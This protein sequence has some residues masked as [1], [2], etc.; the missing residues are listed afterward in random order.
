MSDSVVHHNDSAP[1]T[2]RSMQS[3]HPMQSD[4]AWMSHW[5]KKSYDAAGLSRI[6]SSND[7]Y[8]TKE[9]Q[10]STNMETLSNTHGIFKGIEKIAENRTSEI[11][12]ESLRMTSTAIRNENMEFRGFLTDTANRKGEISSGLKFTQETCNHEVM[13]PLVNHNLDFEEP[14]LSI[15]RISVPSL[16]PMDSEE[17]N[18]TSSG[19][20]H[21]KHDESQNENEP[22]KTLALFGD[23]GFSMSRTWPVNFTAS[24]SHVVQHGL[25]HGD[26]RENSHPINVDRSAST[27]KEQ[28][29]HTNLRFLEREY[30]RRSE[31]L[32]CQ[33]KIESQSKTELPEDSCLRQDKGLFL[34]IS[35][36]TKNN[37]SRAFGGE[38]LQNIQKFAGFRPSQSEAKFSELTKSEKL[39][40]GYN[41]IPKFLN[42]V[43]DTGTMRICTAVDSVVGVRA[44]HPKF[45]QTTRNFFI[46]KKTD[47]NLNKENETFRNSIVSVDGN[48]FSNIHN[49]SPPSGH[50]KI[51]KLQPIHG[52]EEADFEENAKNAN[53]SSRFR[54][55]EETSLHDVEDLFNYK[56]D[57]GKK[58]EHDMVLDI[59]L[60][61]E[62][63][64]ETDIME[65]DEFEEKNQF[66][67]MYNPLFDILIHG[68]VYSYN[69]CCIFHLIS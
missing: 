19:D 45:S 8:G 17:N 39:H 20:C 55:S 14:T 22:V 44:G 32:V 9:Y 49:R 6:R 65:L 7:D 47:I 30:Q 43:H 15:R 64:A 16:L 60:K 28:L 61:N 24:T 59:N 4:S 50:A 26:V 42:S 38:Q 35:P 46:T 25:D 5:T 2:E 40:H 11:A 10:S 18:N 57:K 62:S 34:Q 21:L 13:R 33:E 1:K 37:H 56:E 31:I 66:S 63:S 48:L 12:N 23:S 52:F 69:S 58:V 3:Y 53:A 36:S 54:R 29:Q 68:L 27:S 51:G 41:S 67:G